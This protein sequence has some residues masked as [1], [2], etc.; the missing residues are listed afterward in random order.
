[1]RG[2]R[3][4]HAHSARLPRRRADYVE[5]AVAWLLTS[6]GLLAT[7]FAFVMGVRL[8]DEGMQRTVA[9]GGGRTQVQAVLLEPAPSSFVVGQRTQAGRPGPVPVS[10]RYTAPDGV[11]HVADVWVMGPRPAGT[12]VP[13]WVDRA[14]AVATASVGRADAVRDATFGA[15]AIVV[16]TLLVLGAIWVL[17][18]VSVGRANRARWQSEWAQVEPKW[19]G[20]PPC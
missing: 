4:R 16:P 13:I 15:V 19:S 10:A 6:L 14:G 3:S 7:V 2:E 5:D 8:Y 18:H 20:R 11:E 9:E 12:P 17:V 1:V